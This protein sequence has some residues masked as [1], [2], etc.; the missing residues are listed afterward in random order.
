MGNTR[1]IGQSLG[2]GDPK[3]GRGFGE[4]LSISSTLPDMTLERDAP[5]SP[6]KQKIATAG[7]KEPLLVGGAVLPGADLLPIAWLPPA[8]SPAYDEMEVNH[9]RH[10]NLDHGKAV[11]GNARYRAARAC[12]PPR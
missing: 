6:R 9:E 10:R 7:I 8:A 3:T 2:I 1:D 5:Q 12:S 4:D 11:S